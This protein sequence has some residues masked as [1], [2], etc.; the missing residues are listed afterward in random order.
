MTAERNVTWFGVIGVPRSNHTTTA[1]GGRAIHSVN[2]LMSRFF[3]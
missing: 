1:A 3:F 2:Q